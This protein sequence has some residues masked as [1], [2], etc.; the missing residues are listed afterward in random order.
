MHVVRNA[1]ESHELG[2]VVEE[3]VEIV[4]CLLHCIVKD[5]RHFVDKLF[6]LEEL[7]CRHCGA[8][9]SGSH[10]ELHFYS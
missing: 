3:G 4:G 9:E 5:G 7:L 1:V 8:E 10:A 2:R 6:D